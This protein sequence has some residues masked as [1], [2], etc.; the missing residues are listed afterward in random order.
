[1]I[2]SVFNKTRPF[3]YLLIGIL[4]LLFFIVKVI[5][6]E[7]P[8]LKWIFYAEEVGLFILIF[9]SL[10]ILNFIALKNGLTKNNNY[11][12]FL[13]FVFLLFFSSGLQNKN[14]VISN[15]L[16]L[17]ALRRLI[18]LKSLLSIKEKIFDASLWIFVASIF[19]FW[20]ILF[21]VLVFISFF[22]HVSRDYRN[23]ILPL[24]ALFAAS[25]IFMMFALM[26]DKTR[27]DYVLHGMQTNFKI[28]YF[29]DV[30]QNISFSIYVTMA[31]FFLATLILTFSQRP[32]LLQ[33]SYSKIIIAFI[34]GVAVFLI[35][36][37][38]S[39]E[40]LVFTMAPLSMIATS[41]IEFAQSKL[42]KEL[43]L[44]L[45]IVLAIYTFFSQ[46]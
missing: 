44:T 46:L 23:W 10:S 8:E 39:N 45:T 19:H 2:A 18:S 25:M 34:I 6:V 26:I 38:K 20:S 29:T 9:S 17:L 30:S 13:F 37:D 41:H 14:I 5:S 36:P 3:N 33:S 16:L 7:K 40:L 32:L 4:I 12:L 24:I 28:D 42:Q 43:V 21:I 11:A 27:I 35:S 31:L 15:F 1:M 22:I